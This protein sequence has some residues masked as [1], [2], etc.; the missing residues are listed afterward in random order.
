M[1]QGA[2]VSAVR[3][4]GITA[5]VLFVPAGAFAAEHHVAVDGTSRGDGTEAQ[6]WDLATALAHP[7]AVAPGDT[8]WLHGGT[9]AIVGPYSATLSGTADAPIVVRAAIGERVTLDT[10]DSPDNRIGIDGTQ[11]WYWGFEVMSSAADRW[12]D[13]GNAADRGYS[14]DV[15]S[16]EGIKLIN[17]V[18][19]DT[20][21][22]VGFWGSVLDGEVY[23]TLI[24]HNG[25]DFDDRGHGH[26]I[27]AQNV[28]GTKRLVDNIL[29]GAY[30]YGIHV[31]TEGGQ[32]DGFYLEGNIAF[33]NGVVSSVSDGTTNILIGGTPVANDPEVRSNYTWFEPDQGGTSCNLG[34]GAGTANAIVQ[35]NVF[36]GGT[37]FGLD[38]PNATVSGNVFV[39]STEGVDS[40]SFPDNDYD[41]PTGATVIVRPNVYEEGRAHI[42]AYN[43]DAADAIEADVG[44]VLAAGDV[45]EVRDAQ[46]YFGDPIA[47]GTFSGEPIAIP[48]TSTEVAGVIGEPATPYVHTSASFGAFVLIKTGEDPG[49]EESGEATGSESDDTAGGDETA[50]STGGS[51]E[52]SSTSTTAGADT[53]VGTNDGG[54]T[55]SEG[56][57]CRSTPSAS[58]PWLLVLFGARRRRA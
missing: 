21:G 39:G 57:G 13:D 53:D 31:Y 54:A 55:E 4:W 12:A 25:Y 38:G 23:G 3:R 40:T 7:K 10:G 33:S 56:C 27:Y 50:G 15:N 24:Y 2:L 17:L 35:D 11:T 16:G 9:Y 45:Y 20:Q 14:I 49:G 48:M 29:F 32:I 18:V 44:E 47:T 26:G 43:W 34:Y 37:A 41:A 30:S 42:V 1:A 51:S 6:P 58:L 22:A 28:D 36:V 46:N 52:E 5:A 19:H 8:I